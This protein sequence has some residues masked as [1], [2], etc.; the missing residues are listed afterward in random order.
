MSTVYT[1]GTCKTKYG[2]IDLECYGAP[3]WAFAVFYRTDGSSEPFTLA[4]IG[5]IISEGF[6]GRAMGMDNGFSPVD[7]GEINLGLDGIP[8]EQF[9]RAM[10]CLQADLFQQ[11]YEVDDE[12]ESDE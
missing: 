4:Q 5:E 8:E 7:Y 2:H 3:E 9:T 11:K 1:L 6:G 10:I 12:Y